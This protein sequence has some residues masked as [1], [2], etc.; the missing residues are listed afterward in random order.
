FSFYTYALEGLA[1]SHQP[2]MRNALVLGLGAGVVPKRLAS[3]GVAVTAVEIDPASFAIARRFFGLDESNVK[4]VQADARTYLRGCEGS[5]DA[6]V[7]DLFHGDGTPDY[8]VTRNFFSDLRRCLSPRGV[9]VFNTFA[10]LDL[11]LAYAHFLT[12]L[13]SEFDYVTLYREDERGARHVNSYV[14]AARAPLAPHP[15]RLGAIPDGYAR[16][17]EA[18]LQS[19]RQLDPGLLAGGKVIT[20]AHS[21]GAEDIAR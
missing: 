17:L 7:V 14:V 21:S 5:Y 3:R 6:I 9:V 20:D 1:L 19:G 13:R 16:Q 18:L 4:A 10:D 15:V 12:T 2:D 11:P 8:L